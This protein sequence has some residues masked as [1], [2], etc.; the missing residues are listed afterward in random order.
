MFVEQLE[1]GLQHGALAIVGAQL[2]DDLACDI[3]E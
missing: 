1:R 3:V 2:A